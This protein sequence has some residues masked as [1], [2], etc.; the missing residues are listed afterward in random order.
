MVAMESDQQAVYLEEAKSLANIARW[1]IELQIRRLERNEPEI[2]EFVLQP[3]AD[4]HFLITA[5]AKLRKAADLACQASDISTQIEA[6]DDAVPD[7]R[8]MRNIF[9]HI[10]EYWQ[11]KG[12]G[13]PVQPGALPVLILGSVIQWADHELDLQ[14]LLAAADTLYLAI[15]SS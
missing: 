2:P 1:S 4:F 9:E 5:I 10:D 3:F 11:S 12:R 8:Q 6:F 14:K 7:W 13:A 15:K